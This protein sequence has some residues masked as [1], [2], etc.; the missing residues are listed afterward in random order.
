MKI[1][2][3]RGNPRKE[4][5]TDHITDLFL[6]GCRDAHAEIIE[7]RLADLNVR[8]CNGCYTCW[9]ET[10]GRCIHKDS[11]ATLLEEFKNAECVLL[12]TP[13]YAYSVSGIMKTFLDRTL[14]L[15]QPGF[16]QTPKNL[17]CNNLRFPH[18][19]PKK[20]AAI[21]VGALKGLGNFE[22]LRNTLELFA[23]A[24]SMEFVGL[25]KRDESFLLQ[26][27]LAKPKSIKLLETATIR[28]GFELA[29][30]GL[31][32]AETLEQA[33]IPLA[34]DIDDFRA[35]SDI[36]WEHVNAMGEDRRN[37][38]A[39][40]ERVTTDVRI[41]MREMAR[42]ID[43][44]ATQKMKATLQFD[45]PNINYH[46]CIV[47]NK[48]TCIRTEEKKANPDLLVVAESTTWAGVFTR[49]INVRDALVQ[50]KIVL[51]GDKSIFARL[52]RFFPPPSN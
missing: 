20:L 29:S 26:F 10:P 5:F 43:P 8:P 23:D 35:Y 46:V 13:L 40:R 33:A 2:L 51:E 25:L 18:Y 52:D 38:Q 34:S 4:G 7:Y 39:V 45:F 6:K 14:P 22:G 47:I 9:I 37:P 32:S 27:E 24:M 11:M 50:K 12:S 16:K 42:S 1:L 19:W 15:T 36:Y 28:A 3:I 21:S 31:M 30:Q 49:Q 41:L 17:V 48:G 44:L